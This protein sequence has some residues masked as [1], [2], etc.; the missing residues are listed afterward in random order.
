[1]KDK[2]EGTIVLDGL[3]EGR[4]P[5]DPDAEDKLRKWVRF[6]GDMGIVFNL[7]YSGTSFS[8]LPDEAPADGRHLG[9]RPHDAIR[10]GLDQL[11]ELLPAESRPQAFST[12]R[13]AEYRK[14]EEVQALY[15]VGP[16]ARVQVE[17]RTVEAQTVAPPQPMTVGQRVRAVG[18]GLLVAAAL[19]GVMSLFVDMR[20]LFTELIGGMT[21]IDADTVEVDL[22]GL[23]PF[24]QVQKKEV[25]RR[26]GALVLT[27]KRTE[28]F[29][30]TDEDLQ[31][32]F[33]AA[34]DDLTRRLAVE[35]LARGYVRC[36]L[37]D[38]DGKFFAPA[39]LRLVGLR[40]NE[41]VE[42]AV[43]TTIGSNRYR[44]ARVVVT[45]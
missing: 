26:R 10:Q 24:V 9:A 40:T 41:S 37:Y 11:L 28:A 44:L 19:L 31:K 43:P 35:A 21:S 30:Q 29:P 14:G 12:L 8:L 42:A 27:L 13:S 45:Y 3:I 18:L 38:E 5:D 32:A 33:A 20:G 2:L 17:T 1:M 25:D 34:G 6:M 15:A 7:D 22:K 39:E 36:D 4:F 16:D 23:A